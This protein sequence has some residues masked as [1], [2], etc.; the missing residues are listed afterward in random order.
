MSLTGFV[1]VF[2]SFARL[3]SYKNCHF[4]R[5]GGVFL[6]GM[7]RKENYTLCAASCFFRQ[8]SNNASSFMEENK[9]YKKYWYAVR[10]LYNRVERCVELLDTIN[11]SPEKTLSVIVE[12]P[13]EW[14]D[15]EW[16][17]V[18]CYPRP[19]RVSYRNKGKRVIK[20]V[21]LIS[22][23]LFIHA[24]AWQIDLLSRFF[25]S[26]MRLYTHL[27]K[28][29]LKRV[30]SEGETSSQSEKA[31]SASEDSWECEVIQ[32]VK[33]PDQE[34]ENL[35]F[36]LSKGADVVESIPPEKLKW[37]KGTKVRVID[38]DF[39]GWEGEIR[40]IKCKRRLVVSIHDVHNRE[41]AAFCV[42]TY[43]P[44]CFLEEVKE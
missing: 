43:I 14:K 40:R 15:E 26:K 19:E 36:F 32:P 38:G 25:G 23:L 39:K 31:P 33:I 24:T 10:I 1:P 9:Q 11:A 20:F 4:A 5:D 8:S 30:Q 17:A 22:S 13:Q 12:L 37:G 34:I 28:K 44:A 2:S 41:V 7:R 18:E 3:S 27:G 16:Q 6:V 21:P 29:V 35:K 42:T